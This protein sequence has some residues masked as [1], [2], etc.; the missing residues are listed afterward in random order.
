MKPIQ[1]ELIVIKRIVN[2]ILL[3]YIYASFDLPC[4]FFGAK[5][6]MLY[7]DSACLNFEEK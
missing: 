6:T 2:P 1:K 5:L 3:S 7:K 4:K